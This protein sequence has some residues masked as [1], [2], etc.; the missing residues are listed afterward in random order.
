MAARSTRTAVI[1]HASPHFSDQH[2]Q[3]DPTTMARSHFVGPLGPLRWGTTWA[4]P[5]NWMNIVAVSLPPSNKP[6]YLFHFIQIVRSI[7]FRILNKISMKIQRKMTRRSMRNGSMAHCGRRVA[8]CLRFEP[9]HT[10]TLA[11]LY[12]H[13]SSVWLANKSLHAHTPVHLDWPPTCNFQPLHSMC[14]CLCLAAIFSN[15]FRFAFNSP[16]FVEMNFFLQKIIN[17]RETCW[18]AAIYYV[19]RSDNVGCSVGAHWLN[20]STDERIKWKKQ[21]RF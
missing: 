15:I 16:K 19:G 14:F 2:T 5:A 21:L 13:M 3:N 10:H 17:R 18:N 7:R 20:E 11:H 1:W 4:A 8:T 12:R 6:I 9:C